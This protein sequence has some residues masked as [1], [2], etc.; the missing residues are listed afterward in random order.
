MWPGVV[1]E[2]TLDEELVL[3]VQFRELWSGV[4]PDRG[5][6][7]LMVAVLSEAAAD[8]R[9]Y[10]FARRRDHQRLF[11][12]AYDWIMSDDMTWPFSFL[13]LCHT[14]GFSPEALRETILDVREPVAM[15]QAA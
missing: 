11:V 10:R 5:E 9:R 1:Y 14:L 4:G 15:P 7:E 12:K 2:E 6:T 3:P 8:I 13:N